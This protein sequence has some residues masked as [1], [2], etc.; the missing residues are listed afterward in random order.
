MREVSRRIAGIV[1]MWPAE[2]KKSKAVVAK[3]RT[4]GGTWTESNSINQNSAI[5][6]LCHSSPS[7]V[8]LLRDRKV[9]GSIAST[10][11]ELHR[12][13]KTLMSRIVFLQIVFLQIVFLEVNRLHLVHSFHILVVSLIWSGARAKTTIPHNHE[14]FRSWMLQMALSILEYTRRPPVVARFLQAARP[15]KTHDDIAVDSHV[16]PLW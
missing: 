4:R 15:C 2:L 1:P 12:S 3:L 7:V 5:S 9:C 11:F 16:V 8:R 6:T 14:P 13:K 10:H